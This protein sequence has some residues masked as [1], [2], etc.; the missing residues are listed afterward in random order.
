[1]AFS[2]DKLTLKS[3]EAVQGAQKAAQNRGHQRLEPMHLLV[4]LLGPDQSVIAALLAQLGVNPGQ[5]LKA[6]EEGLNSLPKVSGGETTL[7]QDLARVFE[8]AQ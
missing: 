7:G 1:M 5:I 2:M 3:Q 4:A 6:A 8:T